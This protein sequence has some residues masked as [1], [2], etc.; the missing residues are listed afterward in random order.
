MYFD[1]VD[2]RHLTAFA[3][4]KG[5]WPILLMVNTHVSPYS[6]ISPNIS[7]LIAEIEHFLANFL[8]LLVVKVRIKVKQKEMNYVSERAI[9]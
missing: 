3:D 5:T 4:Q 1:I 7:C 9:N 8:I 2:L 6:S